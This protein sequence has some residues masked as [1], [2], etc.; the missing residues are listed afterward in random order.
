MEN[1]ECVKFVSFAHYDWTFARPG[2]LPWNP[3]AFALI[4]S[5]CAIAYWMCL[6]LLLLVYVT[7]KRHTGVYFYSIIITILGLILQTTGYILKVFE[8]SCPPVLV[9]IICKVG[10]VANVSG[11]SVVLW[12]R[13]HLVVNDPRILRGILIMIITNGIICHTPVVVFEF[14][15]MSKHHST[16]YLPMQ[17][18]ERIQQTVFTI[19]ETIIS[20]LYIYHT[21]R[22]LSAGYATHTRK[23]ISLL[24]CVQVAVVVLDALLTVFDYT[25]KFTL[26]CT[27][28]PLIYSIKLKL[29]FIVL[30]QLQNL[31]KRGL[32]PGLSL[33]SDI[34]PSDSS[35]DDLP[36]AGCE[37][38]E[39][40]PVPVFEGGFIKKTGMG[41]APASV[42]TVDSG[43]ERPRGHGR[44]DSDGTLMGE[45]LDLKDIVGR[46]DDQ[47]GG[48][49][50]VDDIE[51]LY[52]GRWEGQG[53]G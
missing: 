42:T 32:A 49:G 15:L 23:V 2:W 20:S 22:F 35:S 28:H 5:F 37:E 26:K 11:F 25:D 33:A 17:I 45:E 50:G 46:P 53:V 51:R 39:E 47:V 41:R 36:R 52:L 19:Q 13:L 24:L 10:W 1:D 21:F 18:M 40:V 9:T 16:Y 3:T 34:A 27:I 31:V 14:G 48:G 29:E 43:E 4:A 44:M 30:N 12:S 8:N 7:F 38:E 6:E